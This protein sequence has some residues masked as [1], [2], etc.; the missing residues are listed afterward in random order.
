MQHY[1]V[2]EVAVD[3]EVSNG[4]NSLLEMHFVVKRG[5][6]S[7]RGNG[8]NSLLEMLGFVKF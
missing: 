3:V 2:A 5:K 4:F 8:F 6:I 1:G 7:I